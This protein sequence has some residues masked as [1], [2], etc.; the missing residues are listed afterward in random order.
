MNKVFIKSDSFC[1]EGFKS[2]ADNSDKKKGYKLNGVADIHC[3]GAFGHDFSFGSPEKIDQMLDNI[4]STGVTNILA[5]LITDSEKNRIKALQDISV[6]ANA[7]TSPP[8]IEG[9]YLEGPFLAPPKAGSHP[10]KYLMKP[11][12]NAFNH[13]QEVSGG[14]I[15]VITVAP[16]LPGAYEFIK[17]ITGKGIIA[18][19]G[20]SEANWQQSKKAF[21]AG[22]S[23][24]TH[25]FNAM[26]P[27]HHRK[28]GLASYALCNN[29]MSVE[30]IGDC[31]HLAAET[32]STIF[33]VVNAERIMIVSDCIATTGLPDGD[34]NYYNKVISKYKGVCTYQGE[35]FG[36]CTDMTCCINKT[37]KKAQV[38]PEW[39]TKSIFENQRKVFGFKNTDLEVLFDK[40][41]NWIA[42]RSGLDWYSKK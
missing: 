27:L 9:I 24:I 32:I 29:Q 3:H 13:W 22:A 1:S 7:R 25:L 40:D 11:D 5:T 42:T 4:L 33:N 34:Y 28:P 15:K 36:G 30:V 37:A 21:E 8:F 39:L 14:L 41:F 10:V 19:L 26:A 17:A 35:F 18:A 38:L 31:E 2:L 16:E 20:H 12:I 23:H 6:V